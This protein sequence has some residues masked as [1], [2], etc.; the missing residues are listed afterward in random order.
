M[1]FVLIASFNPAAGAAWARFQTS[2]QNFPQFNNPFSESSFGE[3]RYPVAN[4][5][6]LSFTLEK[7]VGTVG[8]NSLQWWDCVKSNDQ[9]RSYVIMNYT[10]AGFGV[11]MNDRQL[12]YGQITNLVVTI[13]C[14]TNNTDKN[15]PLNNVGVFVGL[16]G[17]S[18]VPSGGAPSM[19]L[20][21]G[22]CPEFPRFGPIQISM[23]L[24]PGFALRWDESGNINTTWELSIT[25]GDW[26]ANAGEATYVTSVRADIYYT[27]TVPC[28]GNW[29]ENT[30]CQL[31]RFFDVVVRSWQFILNAVAFGGAI[32]MYFVGIIGNFIGLFGYFFSVPGMPPILQSFLTVIFVGITLFI[33]LVIMGKVRG[34]GNTG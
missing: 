29:F 33:V 20:P 22:T 32:L 18:F 24:I 34:T 23:P 13:Q 21:D 9:N 10:K 5:S 28:A 11:N 14:S 15:A 19:R 17:S 2:F 16:G 4:G 12:G 26:I 30:G 31:G 3:E 6:H 7:P 25:G 1:A 27:G 8:C